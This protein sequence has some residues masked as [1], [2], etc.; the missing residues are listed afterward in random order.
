RPV[1][2]LVGGQRQALLRCDLG[3]RQRAGVESLTV[4]GE[5]CDIASQNGQWLPTTPRQQHTGLL[6]ALA[7]RRRPEAS[8]QRGWTTI[9]RGA[10]AR[11]LDLGIGRLDGSPRED[12]GIGDELAADVAPD[13]EDLDAPIQTV[14][15]EDYGSGRTRGNRTGCRHRMLLVLYG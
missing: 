12:K 2:Q 3:Q 10:A 13:Q 4:A 6:E 1:Q 7:Q 5:A 11:A 15:E 9:H 8:S 14:A